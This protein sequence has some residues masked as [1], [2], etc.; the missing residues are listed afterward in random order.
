MGDTVLG[1]DLG[2]N[3]IG[4]ALLD[5]EENKII[6][7]GSR[8][9]ESSVK[10]EKKGET[11][12]NKKRR[13]S[14]LA[15]RQHDRR[16]RRKKRLK[17][18]LLQAGLLPQQHN[19]EYKTIMYETDPYLLR[20][21]ALDEKLESYELGKV[22]YHL[23]QRRGFKSNSKVNNNDDENPIVLMTEKK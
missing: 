16:S 22:F 9:F 15:R 11:P 3:S 23:I 10:R 6:A 20:K 1:V 19:I 14:R 21:K 2:T 8:I 5:I 12:K 17:K 7:A 18:I 4:W 13:V